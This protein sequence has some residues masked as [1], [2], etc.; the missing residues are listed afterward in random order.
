M[1]L[2]LTKKGISAFLKN[3]QKQDYLKKHPCDFQKLFLFQNRISS[4]HVWNASVEMACL[5]VI[6]IDIKSVCTGSPITNPDFWLVSHQEIHG[7]NCNLIYH[8]TSWVHCYD[9]NE[10]TLLW[11]VLCLVCTMAT[12]CS[13][14]VDMLLRLTLI[15]PR[16][17]R[18]L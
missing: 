8:V 5:L 4:Q 10:C 18:P 2:G 6:Q 13:K 12:L 14:S 15:K 11:V 3:C 16:Q 7:G 9:S 17:K 1:P